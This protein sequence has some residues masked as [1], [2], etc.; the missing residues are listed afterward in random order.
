[1]NFEIPATPVGE[2]TVSPEIKTGEVET[3]TYSSAVVNGLIKGME[4]I[5]PALNI[6]RY[7]ILFGTNPDL[8]MENATFVEADSNVEGL[9][10]VTLSGLRA[11]KNY[12]Y[13]AC[14]VF[15][16]ESYY[17]DV[18]SFET[19]HPVRITKFSVN[20][21][22][23][24]PSHFE[25]NG[26]NYDFKYLCTSYVKIQN[27][28]D[29]V[30]W[31][32]AYIDPYGNT[33]DISLQEFGRTS[34]GDPRYAYFRND[35]EAS[36]K[37][38]GYVRFKEESEII[39]G[40][41]QEFQIEYPGNTSVQLSNCQFVA[42]EKNAEINGHIYDY[43][44][45][46]RFDFNAQG[47]YWLRVGT[48]E[49]GNGWDGWTLLPDDVMTPVDGANVL[50]VNY[51]YN[52]KDLKDEY[53]VYLRAVDTANNNTYYSD[54]YAILKYKDNVFTGCD[55]HVE[56][57]SGKSRIVASSETDDIINAYEINVFLNK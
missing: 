34:V 27:T 30:D 52:E 53:N 48:E 23:Y 4:N 57:E 35:P 2:F 55:F 7:G 14:L 22:S 47:G 19:L 56:N 9:F 21:A 43:K 15:D 1:M 36:V 5:D 16:G 37:L 8:S 46:F 54:E 44:S 38:R 40:E 25:Y 12:Y 10:A 28:D 24:Y 13:R 31:G 41:I 39:Y 20:D 32:Y 29:V 6:V 33:V 17:G 18:K 3:V 11:S 49:R 42:S 45:T 50:T 26:R 51:Y